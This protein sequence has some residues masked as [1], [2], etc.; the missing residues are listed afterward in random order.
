MFLGADI[1]AWDEG[2]KF[3]FGAD[4]KTSVDY[5]YLPA[6]SVVESMKAKID[7]HIKAKNVKNK[8]VDL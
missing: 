3:G 6:V 4:Q 8:S 1:N 5:I 2:N 7:A